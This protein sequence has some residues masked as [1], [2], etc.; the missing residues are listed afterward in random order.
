[1]T[2]FVP[3]IPAYLEMHWRAL[4]ISLLVFTGIC[5]LS[6]LDLSIRHFSVPMVLMIVMLAPLPNMLMELRKRSNAAAMAGSVATFALA[7]SCLFT[8]IHAYPFFF[9]YINPLSMGQPA[10][11]LVNDSNVDWNQSLPEV[12]R[13]EDQHGIKSIRLDEY[14]FSDLQ[15]A[16]AASARAWNCQTPAPD[17]AGQWVALSANLILE[18]HNC[19]W[20]TQYPHEELAGGA[21]Y[22]VHLPSLIPAAGTAG[23]PPLPEDFR[24]FGGM[25]VDIR[26]LFTHLEAQPDDLPK[27]MVWMQ[28]AFAR[29]PGSKE[30]PPKLPWD[31]QK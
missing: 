2:T 21:M 27:A 19:R 13:F 17:D 23:G 4:W 8:A 14:G 12:Q 24:V 9:P 6:P 22:A 31:A 30:P 11:A 18:S 20:L 26:E 15:A 16:A 29:P 28:K 10:Y 5:L 7:A 1:M 25:T 3:A